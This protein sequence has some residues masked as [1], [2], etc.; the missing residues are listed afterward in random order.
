MSI[1]A[2]G[3]IDAK[4][5]NTTAKAEYSAPA[6][7]RAIIDKFTA[8][9]TDSAS[10]TI[11]VYIVPSGD[12]ADDSNLIIDEKS[13]DAGGVADISELQNQILN[14]GDFVSVKA[15]V[16]SKVVIRMSGREV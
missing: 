10:A 7:A 2:K 16:A 1:V 14:P 15:S 6:A 3:L 12:L 9:N 11:S 8:T 4:Y 13:I 5:A